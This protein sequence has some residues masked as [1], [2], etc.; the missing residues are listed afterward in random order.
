MASKR[1]IDSFLACRRLAM[2][3]VSRNPRHFSRTLF[4]AFLDRGYDVVP[5]NP[6]GGEIEGRPAVASVSAI[7]PGV[8]AALLVTPAPA[9]A[10]VVRECAAAGVARIWLYRAGG[11]GAVSPE[12]VRA[13]RER[14]LELVDGACPFMF[15]PGAS[16]FHRA[17]GFFHR[18]G[19]HVT[20]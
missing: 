7:E 4:R 9:S 5:V 13:A 6:N 10:A 18:L 17:H 19:G 20:A 2:V 14:N 1:A 11:E 16:F 3:G 8:Q 15:L 12:A